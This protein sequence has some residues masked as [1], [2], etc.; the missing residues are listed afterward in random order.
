MKILNKKLTSYK[1]FGNYLRSFKI[2][3]W[4]RKIKRIVMHHTS[5]PIE[6]WQGSGSMLH[7]WNLYRSRGWKSGPHIFI[8][9]NGIW[10]FT[11]LN[12]RGR[13]SSRF[14]DKDSIHIE[15]VGQYFTKEP[16]NE[17][18]CTLTNWVISQLLERYN[19]YHSDITMHHNFEGGENCSPYVGQDW[20]GKTKSFNK[21]TIKL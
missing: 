15:I 7:Y 1:Q 5:S 20:V 6:S 14:L 8:A 2:Y 10:L 9:P 12:K 19:L 18:I 3:P 4:S 13:T 11:P 16:D 17:N 21:F